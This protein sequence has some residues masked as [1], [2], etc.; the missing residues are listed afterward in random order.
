M[1]IKQ[2]YSLDEMEQIEAIWY[3]G[4]KVGERKDETYTYV[5]YRIG[6][7]YIEEKIHTEWNVRQALTPMEEPLQGLL[8]NSNN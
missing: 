8:Y 1:T 4:E 6:N 3:K 5:L 2:W 7:L